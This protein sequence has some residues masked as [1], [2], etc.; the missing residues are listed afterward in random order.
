MKFIDLSAIEA[1]TARPSN[2]ALGF[3]LDAE[4]T[5]ACRTALKP[6]AKRLREYRTE[7]ARL[8]GLCDRWNGEAYERKMKE[9]ADRAQAGDEE[10]ATAI[11]TG[12]IPSRQSF[13]EML[14]RACGD[15]ENFRLNNRQVFS[16]AAALVGP[17]MTPVVEKGQRIL[18]ATLKG[19]GLPE[20]KLHGATNHVAFTVLQ[21]EKAGR[22][23]S[24]DLEWFWNSIN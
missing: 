8:Q 4:M 5:A 16:E 6:L 24:S 1:R 2:E 18:D 12:A 19:F 11:E 15:L 3:N 23:E 21:L 10:A 13:N 7:E 22:N 9:I 14:N 20:Y 17:V